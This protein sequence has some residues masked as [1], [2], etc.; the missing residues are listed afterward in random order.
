MDLCFT[1]PG[2]CQKIPSSTFSEN[3]EKFDLGSPDSP[4]NQCLFLATIASSI[5]PKILSVI[6]N[7]LALN[8]RVMSHG[9]PDLL[10]WQ[11]LDTE[12]EDVGFSLPSMFMKFVE[13]KS[14]NDRLSEKQR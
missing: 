10:L 14:Q 9:L 7:A 2:N 6:L 3:T 4:Y 13:V 8:Y 5:K 1:S 12:K 11:T